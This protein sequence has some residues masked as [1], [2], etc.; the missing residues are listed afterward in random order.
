MKLNEDDMG[1]VS[2]AADTLKVKKRKVVKD[3]IKNAVKKL[4]D[5]DVFNPEPEIDETD[6][7]VKV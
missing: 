7:M 2:S 5:S 1:G 3:T 4:K 6:T